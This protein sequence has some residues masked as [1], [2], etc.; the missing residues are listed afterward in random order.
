VRRFFVEKIPY[1]AD[2]ILIPEKEANHIT[3]VLRMKEGDRIIIF[4]GKG[5]EFKSIIDK[6]SYKE[7]WVRII[8]NLSS[9][10]LSPLKITLA[11]AAVKGPA[12]DYILQKAT[13]L[14]VND[15]VFFYSERTVVKLNT[16]NLGKKMIRWQEIIKSASRQ[17]GRAFLPDLK[18]PISFEDLIKGATNKNTLR[19]ILWEREENH[20]IKDLLKS[21]HPVPHVIAVVGPEGGFTDEEIHFAKR[22]DF[23]LLSIG[24]R[25]LRSDTA[26]IALLSILQYEWGDLSLSL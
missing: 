21:V 5:K 13:E 12:L 3:K 24:R 6:V 19:L 23:R 18:P 22:Y 8:K 1:H 26:S 20:T 10:P 11:Q 7:V 17:C 16:D 2:L 25:V 4:D 14:G 9:R 15:V